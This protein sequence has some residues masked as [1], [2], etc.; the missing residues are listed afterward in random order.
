MTNSTFKNIIRDAQ[1][2]IIR[3]AKKNSLLW[4]YNMH[5]KEVVESAEKLLKLYKK[6]DRQIVLIACWLHD[7]SKYYAKDRKNTSKVD[8]S[9]H[10]DSANLGE[11]FLKNYNLTE[12]EVNKIKSC[13]LRHRNTPPYKART[14]EERI[15]ATADTLSHYTSIF[16][17]TYFKFFPDHS[18][19][20]MVKNQSEKLKRDWRDLELLPKAKKL[21]KEEYK[22]LKK[23]LENYNK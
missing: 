22:V 15:I 16:Y 21:V 3:L 9:H 19:E 5:Q 17:F 18:L 14:L 7:I 12:E 13:I 6:A 2:K 4:F 1:Q 20:E 8:K 11:S 10:I 23:L